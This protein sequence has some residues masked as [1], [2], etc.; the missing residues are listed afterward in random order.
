[1]NFGDLVMLAQNYNA[2]GGACTWEGGD[3]T[4]D[5][6]VDFSDLV[7]LAQHYNADTPSAVA[8]DFEVALAMVPEPGG[9]L[10]TGL[11]A[12][13]LQWRRRRHVPN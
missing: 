7:V 2:V 4:G 11:G 9:V 3:F 1:V 8:S 12:F 13:A 10:L 5:G 6:N